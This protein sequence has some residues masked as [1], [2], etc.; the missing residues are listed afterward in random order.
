MARSDV[1]GRYRG[2]GKDFEVELRV[3]VDGPQ[4]TQCVSADY[5]EVT[6]GGT[7]Y[8]GSMRV[9]ALDVVVRGGKVTIAGIALFSWSTPHVS[10]TV[11]IP[12]AA[13]AG[14]S[15]SA[16]LRH[17][18]PSGSVQATYE[19][20]FESSSFRTVDL[21]EA[22]ER[23]VRRFVSYDTGS[24][25][26][27]APR[28]RL[29]HV[30]AYADAGIEM[31]PAGPPTFIDT[32]E[33]GVNNTWSDAELQAAMEEHFSRLS[34]HPRWAIWLLHAVSHDDTRI[35]GLMFDKRGLQRQGCAVF[36]GPER[37]GQSAGAIR[38]HL[39]TCVHELGHGFN[40]MH[41]WQKTPSE[42][43]IP[44]RPAARTWMNYPNRF[45]G[46]PQAYWYPFR[47]TFDDPELAH[48]RHGF[49]DDVIMGGRAFA[50]TAPR[51]RAPGWDVD[52]RRDPGLELTVDMPPS[53]LQGMPVTIGIELAATTGHGRPVP[54]LLGPRSLTVDI[55]IQDP[56]GNEFL[57]EPLVRH[58]HP[59]KPMLLRVGDPPIRDQA[60]IHYGRRGFAFSAPGRYLVRARY[61]SPD[62]PIVLSNVVTITVHAP[63]SR[64][65]RRV[66]SLVADDP[67]V[68]VLMSL[69]GSDAPALLRGNRT[70]SEIIARFP[71]HPF[72]DVARV[73]Q[74]TN[75]AHGFKQIAADGTI[76]VRAPMVD[77][78]VDLA[79]DVLNLAPPE[80]EGPTTVNPGVDPAVRGFVGSR[81]T[82]V[83]NGVPAQ[84]PAEQ[85]MTNTSE[86]DTQ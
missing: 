78:A 54:S 18:T 34:D 30:G 74:A 50:G 46:G 81:A 86:S 55:A 19:C 68:G 47:F 51:D 60:F 36:Y 42:P 65:D 79:G 24:L 33:V 75:L 44:S 71:R 67:Q 37:H 49:R 13:P 52:D 84:T 45:P 14:E 16:T 58:C 56:G 28:R 15:P 1:S 66:T 31:V 83:G 3:D 77:A 22:Q 63:V 39:H 26:C 11:T 73:V 10:I 5:Y 25:P 2:Q 76:A 20:D 59:E 85:V 21:E 17:L 70:L 69:V 40:L 9:D 32:S 29:S 23:G 6:S 43:P 72:A 12:R 62:G 41:C 61:S 7:A 64:V 8:V 53:L 48:L 4:P 27:E 38:D 80:A 35:A 82:D 57:F